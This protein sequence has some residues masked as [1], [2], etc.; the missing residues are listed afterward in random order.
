MH[1]QSTNFK[2]DS[3]VG[4][5]CILLDFYRELYGI[6]VHTVL[7]LFLEPQWI[8]ILEPDTASDSLTLVSTGYHSS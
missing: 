8:V 4:S 5:F 1:T 3:T 2:Y 7:L 6:N